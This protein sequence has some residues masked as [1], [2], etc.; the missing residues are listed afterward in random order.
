L[1]SSTDWQARLE[2]LKIPEHIAVIMDGNGRWARQRGLPRIQGHLMG[3]Q[4]TAR[5]VEACNDIGVKAL[6]VYAFSVENWRRPFEE[7]EGL[8]ALIETATRDEIRRLHENN[9]RL[10]ASGRLS[11]LPATLQRALAE[12][13][14]GTSR[15]TGMVL[16]I[17]INYGGRAELVDAAR[18]MARRAGQ[19]ELDPDTIDEEVFREHLYAPELPDPDLLLRPGGELRIS[20]FLLWEIAYSEIIVMPVLWPDFTEDHLVEAIAE[21]NHRNRRFGG[22]SDTLDGPE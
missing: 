15:N 8:M 2:G 1:S 3:R 10:M 16:N 4:A 22:L 14:E 20:N 11:E 21:F 17:L 5:C 19:G 9:I 7:V 13:R 18:R 6:S 12:G